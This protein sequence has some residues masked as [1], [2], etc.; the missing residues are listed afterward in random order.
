MKKIVL[1]LIPLFFTSCANLLNEKFNTKNNL[2]DCF[3]SKVDGITIIH[4]VPESDNIKIEAVTTN[5]A[6]LLTAA[7]GFE[8]YFWTLDGNS[9]TGN[10]NS[11]SIAVNLLEGGYHL[12]TVVAIDANG[13]YF[14]ASAYIK[15]NKNKSVTGT[16]I[17]TGFEGLEAVSLN[18]TAAVESNIA[19]VTAASGFSTYCWFLDGISITGTA[20]TQNVA[21]S[22]LDIGSHLVSLIA[23]DSN[24]MYY[25]ANT[26]IKKT[27]I[28]EP[29]IK[30]S[31][32]FIIFSPSD[33]TMFS[34]GSVISSDSISLTAANAFSAY[35]WSIDGSPIAGNGNAITIE[36]SNLTAGY[37]LVTVTAKNSNNI[38]YSASIQIKK[39]KSA[40]NSG[41]KPG[42]ITMGFETSD[43]TVIS[44]TKETVGNFINLT[45]T[46]GFS[47]YSWTLDGNTIAGS[48]DTASLDISTLDVGF[49]LVTVTAK[50][51]SLYYSASINIGKTE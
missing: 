35:S 4:T 48:S 11:I 40:E 19:M 22:A 46:H 41:V 2:A 18:V 16:E 13:N 17:T 10:S 8:C 38:S 27:E 45:A 47:N 32:I 30:C 33:D 5:M 24:G 49:H 31:G 23:K 20:E 51:G 34:L 12:V 14:S 3:K 43:S 37:H 6:V 50:S 25:S 42:T 1:L 7:T 26:Y 28:L 44:I 39:S 21:L 36:L 15:I 29:D 9:L